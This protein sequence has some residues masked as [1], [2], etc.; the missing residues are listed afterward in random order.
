[1]FSVSRGIASIESELKL[2]EKE[3]DTKKK[4]E[5]TLEKSF[6][7]NFEIITKRLF[8]DKIQDIDLFFNEASDEDSEY[9]KQDSIF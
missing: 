1:M 2:K 6:T 5:A 7:E 4:Q 8:E 3:T 9:D